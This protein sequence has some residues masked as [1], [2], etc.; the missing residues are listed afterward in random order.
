[1]RAQHFAIGVFPRQR[2]GNAFVAVVP[3]QQM[4]DAFQGTADSPKGIACTQIE[5]APQMSGDRLL[6]RLPRDHGRISVDHRRQGLADTLAMAANGLA[7]ACR[8]MA[9]EHLELMQQV[10]PIRMLR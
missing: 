3:C 1:M 5:S 2:G 9:I 6:G 4:G 8:T 7:A 10:A